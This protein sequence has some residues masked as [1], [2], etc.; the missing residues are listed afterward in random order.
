[1]KTF[2]LKATT[3]FSLPL[4]REVV[5]L[6]A[7]GT[8]GWLTIKAHHQPAICALREGEVILKMPGGTEK[9]KTKQAFLK[10]TRSEVTML[11]ESIEIA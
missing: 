9:W 5:S 3:P 8:S 10:V 1:M 6:H 11:S 4:E 2:T 7:Q